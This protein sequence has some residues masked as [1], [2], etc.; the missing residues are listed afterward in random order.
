MNAITGLGKYFYAI[1][2][3]V[4][5]I[6]HFM[7]ADQMA[8]MAPGGAITVYI[9]GLA[10]VLFAVS[11]LIGKYDKL[12][13]V[14]LAIMLLLFVLLIHLKGATSGDQMATISALKDLALVGAALMYAHSMARDNS[15]IG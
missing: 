12:A 13:A 4:F 1:P 15:I 9:T 7:G 11:V 8:G 2:M 10:F 6:F 5:G 14:L 3:L